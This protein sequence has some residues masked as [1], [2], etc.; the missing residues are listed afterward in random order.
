MRT[1]SI[2]GCERKHFGKGYCKKHYEQVRRHGKITHVNYSIFDENKIIEYDD[3]AELILYDKCGKEITRSLIDIEDIEL[4]KQH[5]WCFLCGYVYNYKVKQLHRYIMNCPDNMVV[6]HIN[7]NRVDNRKCNLRI[8]TQ[9]ENNWNKS[10]LKTNTSGVTGVVWDKSRNKW[11]ARI[12]VDKKIYIL[13]DL[14]RLK[15]L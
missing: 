15:K 14:K 4:V 11:M 13:E 2:E 6:D 1:C 10:L 3:Y 12:E 7:Q 5:K 8:C 9:Q